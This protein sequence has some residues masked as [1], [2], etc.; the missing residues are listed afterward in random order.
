WGRSRQSIG[1]VECFAGKAEMD[2]FL[3]QSDIL[4]CLLPLTS[5]TARILNGALFAKLPP[6]AAIVNC[7][8][9]GHL[10]QADL[11]VALDSGRLSA[12]FSTVIDL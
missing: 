4:V 9:G 12:Q 5:K 6:G 3:G 11:L 2:K 10:V 8:R 1:G 7:G